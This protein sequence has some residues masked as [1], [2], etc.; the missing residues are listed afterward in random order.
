MSTN[1][2][3]EGENALM[4]TEKE[5]KDY[6]QYLYDDPPPC[7][8]GPTLQPWV[9]YYTWDDEAYDND[10]GHEYDIEYWDDIFNSIFSFQSRPD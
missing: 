9:D 7:T 2:H 4:V 6:I 8:N 1:T 5:Y 3:V 10:W